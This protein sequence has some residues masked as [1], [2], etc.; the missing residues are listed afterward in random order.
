MGMTVQ[1]ILDRDMMQ[2]ELWGLQKICDDLNAEIEKLTDLRWEFYQKRRELEEEIEDPK[3]GDG[4]DGSLLVAF[5]PTPLGVI[6]GKMRKT[7][8]SETVRFLRKKFDTVLWKCCDFYNDTWFD[9]NKPLCWDEKKYGPKIVRHW[10]E[11]EEEESH[12]A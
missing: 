5:H 4:L 10:Y 8:I 9:G 2:C 3:D 12:D 11:L 1:F 6:M 7:E